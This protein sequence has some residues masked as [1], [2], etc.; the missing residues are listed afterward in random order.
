MNARRTPGWVLCDHAEDE[1]AQFPADASSSHADPMP[2]K[3]CPIQLEPRP[4]P[5]NDSLRLD[6]DQCPPPANPE[7]L[8]HH[9]EE[10]VRQSKPRLRMLLFENTE[11]LPKSKIFQ[12]QIAARAKES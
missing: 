5:A 8:Q 2:R 7:P 9:P 4:M 6:K 1:F 12:K 10:F 11:L 3:P